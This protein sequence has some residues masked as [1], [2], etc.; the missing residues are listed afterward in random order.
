MTELSN[1][2]ENVTRFIF[3]SVFVNAPLHITLGNIKEHF[4]ASSL[5]TN[6]SVQAQVCARHN[7]MAES[8]TAG[9]AALVVTHGKLQVHERGKGRKLYRRVVGDQAAKEGPRM[10]ARRDRYVTG[11]ETPLQLQ[12]T[13]MRH[14]EFFACHDLSISYR[15]CLDKSIP[16]DTAMTA[17]VRNECST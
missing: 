12:V 2:T 7:A 17:L 16:A 1:A 8:C 4:S 13:W 9:D 10:G 5:C 6:T 11:F 14:V 3:L 15:L